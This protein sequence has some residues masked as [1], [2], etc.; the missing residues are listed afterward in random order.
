MRKILFYTIV[1]LSLQSLPVL[2]QKDTKAKQVL[3]TA[4]E[5]H[6][7]MKGIRAYFTLN[8][9]DVKA[10]LTESFD[11]NIIMQANQFYLSIPDADTWFDG[12]TQW[13]WL[14]GPDE[15]NI[16]EPSNKE[17]SMVNPSVLFSIYKEGSHYKYKGEK[18]DIKNRPVHE[19]EIIPAK[20]TG[21]IIKIIVQINKADYMP[22][23]FHVFYKGDMENIVYI[24]KYSTGSTYPDSTF[25]FNTKEH[26]ETE[27]IDLR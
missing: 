19:I 24:N 14:K 27:I 4:Y 18:N 15:V 25:V 21:D 2:A 23:T 20:K 16:T 26:P 7:A 1:C 3:D 8:I 12:T 11:G 22:V 6:T 9:K 10:K 5:K 17:A 13:V